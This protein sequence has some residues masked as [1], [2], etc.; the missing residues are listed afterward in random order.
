MKGDQSFQPVMPAILSSYAG[1]RKRLLESLLCCCDLRQGLIPSL[2]S[3]LS[4]S[5]V[6]LRIIMV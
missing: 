4:Y 5:R 2:T 3:A 1:N 6:T